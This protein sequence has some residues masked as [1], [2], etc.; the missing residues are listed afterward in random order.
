MI[1][2]T[3][4]PQ[5]DRCVSTLVRLARELRVDAERLR[6]REMLH[7]ARLAWAGR[8]E[9][10]WWK[11]LSEACVSLGIRCRVADLT[12]KEAVHLSRDGALLIGWGA[13]GTPVMLV[14]VAGERV[15]LAVGEVDASEHISTR[16]L[17]ERLATE[18][19]EPTR[20]LVVDSHEQQD[21]SEGA[22]PHSKPL[23]RLLA[24]LRPEASDIWMIIV[25]AFFVGVLNL[26]TPV[27]VEGLV[28]TVAF[29]SVLQP[30]V[31]L[32]I[33]LFAFL[34][35]AAAVLVLQTYVVEIIQRRLFARV[36]ADISYRLPRVRH[37]SWD[38]QYGPEL[39]NRFF[40][41]TTLQK[42]SAHILLDGVVIVLGTLVGMTV[43]GFYHPWLLGYAVMLLTLV[44]GG[45]WALGRGAI[46][47]GIEES[48]YKY[49]L[50]SWLE[51][52]A[53]CPRTFKMD[54]VAGFASDRANMLTG[55][56]LTTR[57]AHFK[58][59]FRQIV[60]VLGLQAVAATVL[61]GFGGWLVIQGQLTLGQLVAAELIV[62]A[63]LG[64]FAKLGKHLEG[65][66]DLLAGVDK[67]GK[68]FD[69]PLERRDGLLHM[70]PDADPAVSLTG[71]DF[72]ADASAPCPT[73]S[74]RVERGERLAV[75]GRPGAGK[76]L[77]LELLYGLRRPNHGHVEVLEI[78]PADV[79]P[80]MLRRHVCLAH[81]GEVFEGT[82]AENVHV[83]RSGVG[84][85]EVRDALQRVGLLEDALRLADG[86][87]TTL[88][89]GG[90][91]L[92]SVQTTLLL[93]ARAVAGAPSVLL[94]DGLLDA[95]PDGEVACVLAGLDSALAGH[96][97]IVATGRQ[98][99]IDWC[100]RTLDLSS[101]GNGRVPRLRS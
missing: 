58:I 26:A 59:L 74:L 75:T 29:G 43:L 21:A 45:V 5:V 50:A 37:D 94:I 44:V 101:P 79:R 52:V 70:T 30:V 54:G 88:R 34:S 100:D 6:T 65:F 87:E 1:S 71:V 12:L 80:D 98:A 91:P 53:R 4:S 76:S 27:A 51:D 86:L 28:N 47:S 9:D 25:F 92:S 67:L 72:G 55:R 14:G 33:L 56:Y 2:I 90:R 17:G 22:P 10:V 8:E 24:I 97:V 85:P 19:D 48:K 32:S 20:W 7:Q 61:L 64:S 46:P 57:R 77:L 82:L 96:T 18:N 15:Q 60:F 73:V 23:S 81:D 16:E 31:V 38:R 95:L 13:V 68:L 84:V 99:V 62:A 89:A 35:F 49:R 40:E 39:V 66:Y 93:I 83:H 63:I 3:P 11:W 69:L 42:V 36:A 41:V 78:D